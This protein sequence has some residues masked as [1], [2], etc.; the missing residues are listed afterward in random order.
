MINSDKAK[1]IPDRNYRPVLS[2]TSINGTN[3]NNSQGENLGQIKDLMINLHTGRIEYAVLSFGGVMGIGDKLFAVP[4]QALTV[5]ERNEQILLDVPKERLKNAPGFDKNNWP[6]FADRTLM[7]PLHTFYGT[8][9]G[10][11][12]DRYVI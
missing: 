8:T 11:G 7:E 2:A 6:N 1:V 10:A 9:P 5:D 12:T 3:V 4:W